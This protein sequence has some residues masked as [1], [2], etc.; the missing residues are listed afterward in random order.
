MQSDK[1]QIFD[2]TLRDGEQ[3]PGCKLDTQQ[4]LVIAER[5]DFLGVDVIEAGFPVSSPGDFISVQ[6]IAK[7]VKNA[8][9]CGLTR[10]VKKDIEVAADALRLASK[11][12]IHTG[13][14]TSD[15]HIQYK[16]NASKEE[17]I[18]RAKEAVSYAKNFVDDVEFYA[19]DAGRTDNAFLAKVCEEVIKSGATVLNIPDTTG[20]CLPEEYGAKIKYLKDN[21]KGIENVIISCHCHNDLGLATA[22]SI[23]GAINGA[24]QIECTVNGIGERAGNTALEEVVMILKQH[25]YLNLQTDINTKLLYDTSM[26]VRERM[27]MPVQPNK[28]IVGAN[29]FAHSSGIHQ[30]GV[31]KNR[32]TYEIINPADV[33]VTESAIVLT[34]RSGRA[35]LAY[36]AKKIGYELTKIQLDT[37][38]KTFLQFADR[39]KEV[40]DEDIHQIM[41][42][43]NKI[44]KIAIA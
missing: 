21:V 34:A 33:G 32:E 30:D 36:R 16:F 43:V 6:E 10:A 20:Y 40:I 19:E 31:I 13:I 24:R 2:T 39:Q 12:R 8:T 1:I 5:L 29:A 23:A 41:K 7:L 11:P 22:N 3:V 26:M 37:A 44:S 28:A 27:G 9:V 15:S 42:Q 25:P 4:K 18:R 35:A 14:G 17:V 38:Y